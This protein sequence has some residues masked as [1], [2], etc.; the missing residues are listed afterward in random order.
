MIFLR[1]RSAPDILVGVATAMVVGGLG[2]IAAAKVEPWQ[3]DASMRTFGTL[4][5]VF[6]GL[7]SAV[8]WNQSAKLSNRLLDQGVDSPQMQ[9][10]ANI[11]N[12]AAATFTALALI[13]SVFAGSPWKSTSSWLCGFGILL[14][15]TMSGGEIRCAVPIS[16][17]QHLQ[18]REK[19]GFAGIAVVSL[20]FI[21]NI[22][23]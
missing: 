18:L 16:L 3:A 12:G 23:K 20:A 5:T 9:K 10:D 8:W 17:S 21:W 19:I 14:L 6:F 1:I 13:A 7:V 2:W 15:L 22:L 11:L 4:L